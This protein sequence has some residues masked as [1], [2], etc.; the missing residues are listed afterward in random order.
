MCILWL[1]VF[2]SA[3]PF[4]PINVVFYRDEYEFEMCCA[5][6]VSSFFVLYFKTKYSYK[7]EIQ[8]GINSNV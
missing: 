8:N 4:S 6:K 5:I 2:I 7:N 3:I 1:N